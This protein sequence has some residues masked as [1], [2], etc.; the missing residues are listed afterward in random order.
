MAGNEA[1]RVALEYISR[2]SIE[3]WPPIHFGAHHAFFWGTDL[4]FPVAAH[5]SADM[6]WQVPWRERGT[7][8][9]MGN[10]DDCFC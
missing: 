8:D 6:V 1:I 4:S 7:R 3:L 5:A 2:S 10:L 9:R